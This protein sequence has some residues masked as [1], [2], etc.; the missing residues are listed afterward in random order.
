MGIPGEGES[1][2]EGEFGRGGKEAGNGDAPSF[3]LVLAPR[4]ALWH[5]P[6][7]KTTWV[8]AMEEPRPILYGVSDYAPMCKK[9]AWFA[10][11][12][13]KMRDLENAAAATAS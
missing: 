3:A 7:P 2:D 8:H 6:V 4:R 11:R 13:A 10:D 1:S 12:T 5:H 9:N